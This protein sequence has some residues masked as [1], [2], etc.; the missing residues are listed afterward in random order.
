M[1]PTFCLILHRLSQLPS[2]DFSQSKVWY[3]CVDAYFLSESDYNF[4]DSTL[5]HD[6]PSALTSVLTSHLTSIRSLILTTGSTSSVLLQAAHQAVRHGNLVLRSMHPSV[7][8][9]FHSWFHTELYL[10]VQQINQ[11]I[12]MY[13]NIKGS[14]NILSN[15]W[16]CSNPIVFRNHP[17]PSVEHAY[18]AEKALHYEDPSALYFVLTSTTAAGA[19][20]AVH[21]LRYIHKPSW[22][23][24]KFELMKQLLFLKFQCVPEF[25]EK[26]LKLKGYVLRHPLPDQFWGTGRHGNGSDHFSSLL[27]SL[28]DSH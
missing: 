21:H 10:D 13:Y 18:Q 19:K 11:P 16:L 26:L 25:R 6:L 2:I 8:T 15:F 12:I 14:Q 9:E 3:D 27:M 20:A 7:I 4:L 22:H 24:T 1:L 5:F 28:R 17:F 23:S